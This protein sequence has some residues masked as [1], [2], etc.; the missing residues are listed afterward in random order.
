MP[1]QSKTSVR[2][3]LVMSMPVV[4]LSAVLSDP[5]AA[6][7]SMVT[8][9]PTPLTTTV[10]S[11]EDLGSLAATVR[12]KTYVPESEKPTCV[13]NADTSPNETAP[14][15]NL[16]A[17]PS[18]I[19]GPLRRTRRA[20]AFP[21]LRGPGYRRRTPAARRDIVRHG[22]RVATRQPLCQSAGTRQRTFGSVLR[23]FTIS[24]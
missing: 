16:L 2:S 18:Q 7:T 20:Q 8:T 3:Q 23:T 13:A 5:D 6:R 11:P 17:E 9:A 21:W 14:V 19:A 1:L 22:N 24:N 12:L 4:E 10:R 15:N